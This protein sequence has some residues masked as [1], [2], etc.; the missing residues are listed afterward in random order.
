NVVH[1]KLREQK[2]YYRHNISLDGISERKG[3]APFYER[4]NAF[5][6]S[7]WD[8]E[9]RDPNDEEIDRIKHEILGM[10]PTADRELM[11]MKYEKGMELSEI[12]ERTGRSKDAVRVTL[13]RLADKVTAM[14]RNYFERE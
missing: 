10:L 1:E 2:E 3:L 9:V 14:V 4:E 11:E 13:S 6:E 5:L 12:A 7:L 8:G